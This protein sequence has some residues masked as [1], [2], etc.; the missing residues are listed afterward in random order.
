MRSKEDLFQLIQAMSKTEKRYFVLDAK[1]SGRAN[2]RYLTL[3]EAIN[4]MDEKY[5]EQSLK[6]K[7]P[8]NLSTDK[9][10]LYEA[11][12]RS[13]R[14]YRSQSSKA[15][16]MKERLID[17]KFLYE[18]GL[19]DQ[20]TDRIAEAKALATELEDQFTLLEI[21]REEQV[22][23]FDRRAKVQLEHIE[24]LNE[25]RERTLKAINEE[26]KYLELYYR[27]QLETPKILAE[28]DVQLLLQSNS[29][30]RFELLEEKNKPHFPQP[31]RRF[32]QCNMVYH[33]IL[34]D[35]EKSHLFA[36][37]A[38]E[39]WS[40]LPKLKEE[41][42]YRFVNE[43]SNLVNNCFKL[44]DKQNEAN[45]WYIRLKNEKPSS[46]LHNQ[47]MIFRYVSLSKLLYH[48]NRGDF[49]DAHNLL[50]D[51][52]DGMNKFGL[53]KNIALAGNI[54]TV[55]FL[56]NDFVNCLEWTNKITETMK[57]SGRP[58]VQRIIR[59]YKIICQF[60]LDDLDKLESEIRATNR[61]L[62]LTV[63]KNDS[64]EST[65]L[66]VYLRSI[67]DAPI[68]E[69]KTAVRNF[70]NYLTEMKNTPRGETL[71]GVDELIIWA[72]SKL[73]IKSKTRS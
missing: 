10:Y 12:L 48:L 14:D 60:E 45:E 17:A 40:N 66:N 25:E 47:K 30:I 18:R 1:K 35:L 3:F 72:D 64:F 69:Y 59:I 2:S 65:I 68:M 52:I 28:K 5:D 32:Y 53:K 38:V 39:W 34:G 24:K 4:Q 9:A 71:L 16:Q 11:I 55:Y 41:E 33:N 43:V 51:I 61:Y 62:K 6:E 21:N 7:F 42:F 15:A 70:K 36:T 8:G 19:Y 23:L 56:V 27:L 31:L 73:N 54:A 22:S 44:E 46:T 20:S 26:L 37:K 13:M 49:K 50:P 58:E 63:G 29:K 67:F 57:T